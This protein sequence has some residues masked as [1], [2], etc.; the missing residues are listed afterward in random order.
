MNEK[1]SSLIKSITCL[2]TFLLLMLSSPKYVFAEPMTINFDDFAHGTK[3]TDAYT[4]YGVKFHAFGLYPIL[5]IMLSAARL[6]EIII[7]G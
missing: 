1:S 3:I 5:H 7:T 4:Q 2:V 6:L